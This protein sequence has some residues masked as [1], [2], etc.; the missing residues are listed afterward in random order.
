MPTFPTCDGKLPSRLNP[1][2]LRHYFLLTYWIY[3]RPSILKRYL[4]QS[5]IR[6]HRYEISNPL[7]T[8]SLRYRSHK[9][10]ILIGLLSSLLI[11]I[12]LVM[13][14]F[15]L[16]GKLDLR[17]QESLIDVV[18]ITLSGLTFGLIYGCMYGLI[19]Y[20]YKSPNYG[21]LIAIVLCYG[22]SITGGLTFGLS[23]ALDQSL[24]WS[25]VATA[26]VFGIFGGLGYSALGGISGG[27]G[28]AVLA[29]ILL[30]SPVCGLAMNFALQAHYLLP[31]VIAA[32]AVGVAR[33]P[34]Y[35][36]EFTF[37]LASVVW[38][39][40]LH[41]V[42]WDEL[43]VLPMPC[44]RSAI[45]KIFSQDK[46]RGLSILRSMVGNPFQRIEA[47]KVSKILLE[48]KLE[49][50]RELY[51]WLNSPIINEYVFTPV[52]RQEFDE[53]ISFHEFLCSAL[54]NQWIDLGCLDG[55]GR[56]SDH[57]VHGLL[58]IQ[59]SFNNFS[60][61]I[62]MS[63]IR[64]IMYEDIFHLTIDTPSLSL[65][66]L[67]EDP[68]FPEIE[69]S[70]KYLNRAANLNSTHEVIGFFQSASTELIEMVSIRPERLIRPSV[71]K[72]LIKLGEIGEYVSTA[73]SASSLVNKLHAFARAKSR[74]QDLVRYVTTQV[75]PGYPEQ[76][77]L[78]R[79]ID[80]WREIITTAAGSLSYAQ[81]LEPIPNPYVI[82][83]PVTGSLFVGRDDILSR[84]EELWRPSGQLPSILLYG[85]RRMGKTSILQNLDH[86][87][88]P[89]I[90]I[91]DFNLQRVAMVGRHNPQTGTGELL[92]NLA[93]NLYDSLPAPT[94][95]PEPTEPTFT[96]Q[97]PYAA[98]DRFLQQL[99]PHRHQT[100]YIIALDEFELLEQRI[101]EGRLDRELLTYLR[102]LINTY[103]WFILALAGLH[104][105]QEMTHDYWSPLFGNITPIPVS[106]L[107]L[108]AATNLITNPT[109]DFPIDY[110][111]NAITEIYNLTGGQPYLL[112][113]I[114]H[115]LVSRFN[116]QRFE[117]NIDIEP[118]FSL[119]D[120]QS[121]IDSPTFFSQGNAYFSGIWTQSS[122][123][124]GPTQQAIL[125]TLSQDPIQD[126]EPLKDFQR[127]D[128][129]AEALELLQRHDIIHNVDDRY[130]FVVP[131][132]Q[133]WV[134]QYANLN[135]LPDNLK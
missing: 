55:P 91:I 120:V 63:D 36:F 124:H 60:L 86:H 102:S 38:N 123:Q 75:P 31:C 79:I 108:K 93:L 65:D 105:L 135:E 92:H 12:L 118:R 52:C 131:L 22:S 115:N 72:S 76:K 103:P 23:S 81:L 16:L 114:C 32:F 96:Q 10:L 122:E 59:S 128:D 88:G 74:L 18:L 21:I 34:F 68:G 2:N 112:Q 44:A 42:I 106:F 116:H 33:A 94:D 8:R 100:R 113:L 11:P 90:H 29:S 83:N 25:N 66:K 104:N 45:L 119:A 15:Y 49:K 111:P 70:F 73:T 13:T 99:N 64:Y 82:G 5:S 77:I 134:A 107:T 69:I 7:S 133:R 26:L 78:Y 1:L 84:I 58:E 6:E 85:H 43:T 97:N 126:A 62:F 17:S 109:D 30:V 80:Q 71:V 50:F 101:N 9:N 127:L 40:C 87:L 37:A 51:S 48:K 61:E 95:F 3:F 129:Y 130:Q 46:N 14:G 56:I 47:S 24:E 67:S 125:R 20:K 110:D 117:D 41:P 121:V 53:R 19:Y 54:T 98:F 57:L 35:L 28:Y 89:N 27:V 4:H 132:M 39:P